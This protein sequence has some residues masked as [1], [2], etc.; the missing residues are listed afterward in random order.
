MKNLIKK[1]K[2]RE[3]DKLLLQLSQGKKPHGWLKRNA[4]Y[5]SWKVQT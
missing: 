1:K 5:E 3:R 4:D 2:E